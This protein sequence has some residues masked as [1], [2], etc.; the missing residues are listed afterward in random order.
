[1]N[2]LSLAVSAAALVLVACGGAAPAPTAPTTTGAGTAGEA[3]KVEP[4]KDKSPTCH[5]IHELCEPFEGKGGVAQSCH[6][7]TYSSTEDQCVAKKTECSA[8][9]A[10]K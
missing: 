3:A 5:E 6:D 9:C 2:T 7:M 8:A 10:K 4:K 1:M